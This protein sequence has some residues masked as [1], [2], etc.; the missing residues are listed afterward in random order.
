MYVSH[1]RDLFHQPS[2]EM[3]TE[4]LDELEKDW[5]RPFVDY[6][7]T[8]IHPEVNIWRRGGLDNFGCEVT[9]DVG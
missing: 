8:H 5:S 3:Y 6:F 2:E 4:C 1:L 7:M 9:S